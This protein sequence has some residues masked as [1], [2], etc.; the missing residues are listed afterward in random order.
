MERVLHRARGLGFFFLPR[1]QSWQV[2]KEHPGD[3]VQG[4]PGTP[5]VRDFNLFPIAKGLCICC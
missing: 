4:S 1:D 5:W 3:N 2:D